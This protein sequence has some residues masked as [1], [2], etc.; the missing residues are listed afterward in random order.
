MTEASVDLYA[1]YGI[2]RW[3][4]IRQWFASLAPRRDLINRTSLKQLAFALALIAG[5][6]VLA[7]AVLRKPPA[8]PARSTIAAPRPKAPGQ[9]TDAPPVVD[10]NTLMPIDRAAAIAM[11]NAVPFSTAPN[12]AAAPFVL[13]GT[14]DDIQ[15]ATDCLAAAVLYEAGDDPEGQRAVAQVV[16]NRVRH[17]AFPNSVCGVVFQGSERATGCQFTFTCDGSL[18]RR[19]PPEIWEHA[20]EVAKA[21]ISGAVYP[22]VGMATHYHTN[23]VVPYWSSSLDKIVAVGTH[24]FFRWRGWW[25]TPPAFRQLPAEAE[26][27]IAAM[28]T[29]SDVHKPAEELTQI[30]LAT[31]LEKLAVRQEGDV[32]LIGWDKNMATEDLPG[33]AS[34]LCGTNP[35]CRVIGWQGDERA[36]PLAGDTSRLMRA[37]FYFQPADGVTL[38]RTL[39]DC[40]SI[41]RESRA[42]CLS[43]KDLGAVKLPATT[44]AGLA[45]LAA[46]G[47][48]AVEPTG[49]GAPVTTVIPSQV[50]NIAPKSSPAVE[51]A[52]AEVVPKR[53]RRDPCSAMRMVADADRIGPCARE[54]F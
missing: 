21:A 1:G 33:L 36:F 19:Y 7:W 26:A 43:A 35:Q 17:P 31:A 5:I 4:R 37:A 16:L 32:F 30:R 34:A 44:A 18:E 13:T 52:A 29:L 41:K 14:P 47:A 45:L 6:A 46:P 9:P 15:R 22:Q 20:Q 25:G 39:W 24:L 3:S 38:A 28:A 8:V 40:K 12:P 10:P 27:P 2:G 54:D 23:W 53:K 11:N 50:E 49:A 48:S 51:I 42:D